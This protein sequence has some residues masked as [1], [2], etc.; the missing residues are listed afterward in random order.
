MKIYEIMS[1]GKKLVFSVC[2]ASELLEVEKLKQEIY[3]P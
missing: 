1:K 2:L 3:Q